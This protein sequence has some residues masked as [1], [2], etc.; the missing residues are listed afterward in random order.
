MFLSLLQMVTSLDPEARAAAH[1]LRS[2]NAATDFA[3]K[4]VRYAIKTSNFPYQPVSHLNFSCLGG[5]L[6]MIAGYKKVS[7]LE[8]GTHTPFPSGPPAFA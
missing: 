7:A 6:E 2:P 1:S 8:G 3:S 5:Q 4:Q